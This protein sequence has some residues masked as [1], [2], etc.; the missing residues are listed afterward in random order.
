MSRKEKSDPKLSVVED[1]EEVDVETEEGVE[2]ETEEE[3]EIETE[4][5]VESKGDGTNETQREKTTYKM[6]E[7]ESDPDDVDFIGEH[8]EGCNSENKDEETIDDDSDNDDD[9]D[10]DDDS[11]TDDEE[12]ESSK[13]NDKEVE[14]EKNK[15]KKGKKKKKKEDIFERFEFEVEKEVAKFV[16]ELYIGR[17]K[18]PRGYA[19]E[20]LKSNPGST[21]IVDTVPN[22]AGEDGAQVISA[23][24]KKLKIDHISSTNGLVISRPKKKLKI[25]KGA[26]SAKEADIISLTQPSQATQATIDS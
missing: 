13:Q 21:A 10:S 16:D 24:K 3:V 15:K 12:A 19:E 22:A 18:I 1:T 25:E 14:T 2:I 17:R 11:G 4:E 9:S 7:E 6:W 20:I 26:S 8:L 23:R 5:E